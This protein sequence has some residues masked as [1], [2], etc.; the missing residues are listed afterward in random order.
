MLEMKENRVYRPFLGGKMLDELS[1]TEPASDGHYPERWICSTTAASDGT[2]ISVTTDGK[3]LTEYVKEPLPVLV[4]LL[5]SYSRLM[6]QVHPDDARA[7]KYFHSDKGKAESWHILGTRTI[8]GEEPY[9]YL[10]FKKGITKEK[11]RLLYEKQD[12]KGME[13]CLHKIPVKSGDTFF[14]PGGVPHAMG[15]QLLPVYPG[16]LDEG[17]ILDVLQNQVPVDL[18]GRF[19]S[20]SCPFRRRCHC[21]V[22]IQRQGVWGMDRKGIGI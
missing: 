17:V 3:L 16:I 18:I 10:G 5:D 19:L 12:V 22:L 11:W 9:V 21:L 15:T 6:I 13:E 14:V 4:K 20:A 2:G 1:G 7:A 8:H